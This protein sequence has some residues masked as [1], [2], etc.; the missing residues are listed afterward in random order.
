MRRSRQ[1]FFIALGQILKRSGQLCFE[2]SDA[3]VQGI[4]FDHRLLRWRSTTLL[5][6]FRCRRAH[7][8]LLQIQLHTYD[9]SQTNQ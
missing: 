6:G 2:L 1:T 8:A 5:F 9:T 3:L 7:I 4:E